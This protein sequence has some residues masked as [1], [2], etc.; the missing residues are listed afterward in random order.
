M[1]PAKYCQLRFSDGE[2]LGGSPLRPVLS[3][4]KPPA[5]GTRTEQEQGGLEAIACVL[6]DE[7]PGGLREVRGVKNLDVSLE[8]KDIGLT[9]SP[10]VDVAQTSR[11]PGDLKVLHPVVH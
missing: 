4:L 3:R 8:L 10:G 7:D 2:G 11:G 5:R 1:V 9:G 6:K